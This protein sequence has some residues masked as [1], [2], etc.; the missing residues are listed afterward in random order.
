MASVDIPDGYLEILKDFGDTHELSRTAVRR[1]AVELTTRKMEEFKNAIDVM[2]SKYGCDYKSFI[3]LSVK[4]DFRE[5]VLM[6]NKEWKSD[7]LLWEKN[8][9]ELSVWV[10]RVAKLIQEF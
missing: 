6:P 5:K 3:S 8:T 4:K 2:E 9:Q 10:E 7:L 1:Y